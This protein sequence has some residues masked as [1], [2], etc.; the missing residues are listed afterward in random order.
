MRRSYWLL[1]A[2]ALVLAP[3]PLA[4]GRRE[5]SLEREL[6]GIARERLAQPTSGPPRSFEMG[7]GAI[8]P[9]LTDASYLDT[10]RSI[11]RDADLVLI[12]RTP[13][14]SEFV[15]SG[16]ISAATRTNTDGE[17]RII[18][19]LDLN[20]LYAIDPTDAADR[21]RLAQLPFELQGRTFADPAIREAFIAYA[22]YVA[23]NYHPR[24]LALGVE[25]NLGSERNPDDYQSWLSC[26]REAYAAV[27][28]V[29][30]STLVFPT[31]QWEGLQGLLPGQT[32][33]PIRWELVD[34]YRPEIDAIAISTFPS[35]AFHGAAEIP[36]DYYA[37]LARYQ[38]DLPIIFAAVGYATG[39]A[40]Q[41]S[42]SE[43]EQAQQRVLEL[44]L[45]SADTLAARA[46]VWF[47]YQDPTYTRTPPFDVFQTI[48]LWRADGAPKPAWN[49]WRAAF[50]RPYRPDIGPQTPTATPVA[51]STPTAAASASPSTTP[52]PAA[53]PTP[54]PPR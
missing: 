40:P 45:D 18:H 11:G 12:Q 42:P 1:L 34:A 46:V 39:V 7:F 19:A 13:P 53:T 26:Y 29:S 33:G 21:G 27:K 41:G 20:L 16:K 31:F 6:Q 5:S 10:F 47:T 14:W 15:P 23:E 54:T 30:P 2:L 51:S 48:G 35:L 32:R 28:R 50:R 3:L 17:V 49:G 43:G 38:G 4:C 25:V 9:A 36:A 44:I 24:Y 37:P 8:P 22:Q 52:T